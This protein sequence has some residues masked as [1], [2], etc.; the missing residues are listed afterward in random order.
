[1]RVALDLAEMLRARASLSMCSLPVALVHQVIE[2]LEHTKST[3]TREQALALLDR[4]H[5]ARFDRECCGDEFAPAL[6]Q[7]TDE[8]LAAMGI[9]PVQ[10]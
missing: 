9:N 5:V 8:C 7:A 2:S 10:P 1:M 6:K 4:Y 3:V